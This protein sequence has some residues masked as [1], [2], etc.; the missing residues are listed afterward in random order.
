[1][2]YETSAVKRYYTKLTYFIFLRNR[3][4]I[5]ILCLSFNVLINIHTS[6]QTVSSITQN[7]TQKRT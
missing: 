4:Y 7:V 3:T 5:K 2:F 6:Y 1:V